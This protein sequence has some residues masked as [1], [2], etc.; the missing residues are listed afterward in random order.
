MKSW[1]YMVHCVLNLFYQFL[2]Y[3]KYI[4][5]YG[6]DQV[7]R[8]NLQVGVSN[9]SIWYCKT[10]R[11]SGL[12]G[13]TLRCVGAVHRSSPL[14]AQLCFL[15]VSRYACCVQRP[16]SDKRPCSQD[17][18]LTQLWQIVSLVPL[19]SLLST[20]GVN[21]FGKQLDWMGKCLAS[22]ERVFGWN[23]FK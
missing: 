20:L 2:M 18:W 17:P 12:G 13:E 15:W 23:I 21:F 5:I 7:V 19:S 1:L 11:F 6:E 10:D 22:F 8:L 14:W 4:S 16:D 9:I 3:L